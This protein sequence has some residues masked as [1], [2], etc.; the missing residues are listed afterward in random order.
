MSVRAARS[1][2]SSYARGSASK[3]S[4]AACT[5]NASVY[6]EAKIDTAASSAW[7]S[8]SMPLS[9]GHRRRHRQGQHRVDDRDVGHQRVVDQGLLAPPDRD[10][11]GRRHLRAGARRWS[12]P[13]PAARCARPAGSPPPACGVEERQRQ[14]VEGLLRVLVEEP[15]RLGGVD[16]RPA[17]DGDDQVGPGPV[18]QRHAA[19]D[20]CLVRLRLDLAEDLHVPGAQR[21]ADQVDDSALLARGVGDHDGGLALDVAQVVQRAG[22]EEG[23]GRHPEPLRRGAPVG[24]RLDVQQLEVVDVLGRASSRPRCRSRART[25]GSGCCRPRPE[26]RPPSAR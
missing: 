4:R 20:G 1:S 10:H 12:A 11:R 7:V 21:R 14:V 17:T 22:V 16:D 6:G 23:V 5:Q 24:H 8:A 15:H 25:S 3:I 13:R 26:R 19:P 2:G 18:E 9:G